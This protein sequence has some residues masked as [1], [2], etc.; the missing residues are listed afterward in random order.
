MLKNFRSF[1][2]TTVVP[3]VFFCPS[4]ETRRG[5]KVTLIHIESGTQSYICF[6]CYEV[7]SGF[8]PMPICPTG[9]CD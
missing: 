1:L 3:R 2:A 4:C 5:L 9:K 7:L 6:D 8:S